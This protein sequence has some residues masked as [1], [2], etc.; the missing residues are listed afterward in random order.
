MEKVVVARQTPIGGKNI[1]KKFND[2]NDVWSEA[3]STIFLISPMSNALY[4]IYYR[5]KGGD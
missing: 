5:D 4:L 2:N 1:L 3:N